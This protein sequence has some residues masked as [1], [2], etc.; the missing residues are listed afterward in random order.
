MHFVEE[1]VRHK[2]A[3]HTASTPSS[4]ARASN[5]RK[6]VNYNIAALQNAIEQQNFDQEGDE[7]NEES[8]R[9]NA[10]ELKK[11]NRRFE[12]L[13]RENFSEIHKMEIPKNLG[14]PAGKRTS[15]PSVAVKRIL[16][17]KKNWSN[18]VDELDKAE[19]RAFN[20]H[21]FAP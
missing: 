13:D 1:V 12:E 20:V 11:A 21:E 6:R 9:H 2:P 19:M 4:A 10:I 18:Y 16:N 15:T 17:S 8:E 3:A 7:E 14:P 5:K